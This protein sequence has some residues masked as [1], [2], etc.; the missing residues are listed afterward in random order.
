MKSLQEALKRCAQKRLRP[1]ESSYTALFF[2][3]ALKIAKSFELS[4]YEV[5]QQAMMQNILPE[6]YSRNQK[7]LSTEEQLLLHRSHVAIIGLGGLGGSVLEILSR[8]GIGKLSIV[9]GDVFDE[10]NLNRQLLSTIENLGKAKAVVAEERAKSIN[11]AIRIDSHVTFFTS[12]NGAELLQGAQIAVD[13]L[14]TIRDRFIL[15]KAC[16]Q[17]NIPMVSAAIGG[18]YGQATVIAPGD[19]GLRSIYGDP[20]KAP[21][22]GLEASTG[23]LGFAAIHMATIECSEVITNLLKKESKLRKG[24]LISDISDHTSELIRF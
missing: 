10:S 3:D 6:R 9:D 2:V 5:E 22:R 20:D 24:L 13:C 17:M 18:T 7:T 11:P 4:L 19:P 8:I 21:V 15:E 23:T 12:E 14:D 16:L 1:D